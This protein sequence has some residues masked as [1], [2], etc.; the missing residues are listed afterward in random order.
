[1]KRSASACETVGPIMGSLAVALLM[2]TTSAWVPS[3]ATHLVRTP[4]PD[5]GE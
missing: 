1:M 4:D 2:R 3:G 5:T